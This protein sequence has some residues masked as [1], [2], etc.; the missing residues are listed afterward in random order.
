M[1]TARIAASVALAL[2]A[3][4]VVGTPPAPAQEACVP[5]PFVND[6]CPEWTSVYDGATTG[7]V[8]SIDTA[9]AITTAPG[10][11]PIF[12]AG[13]TRSDETG[14][15]MTTIAYAASGARLWTARYHRP[16]LGVEIAS[17]VAVSPD[18]TTVFTVG[19]EDVMVGGDGVATVVAY[20]AAT[21]QERWVVTH[22]GE[23]PGNDGARAVVVSPD[24][25]TLYVAMSS[26]SA[27]GD[28]DFLTLAL[29]AD[30]G[31]KEWSD[32]YAGPAGWGDGPADIALAPDSSALYVAGT[33]GTGPDSSVYR[34]LAYDLGG[35]EA[36]TEPRWAA[37]YQGPG[38]GRSTAAAMGVAVDGGTV[39][40]AGTSDGGESLLDWATVAFDADTGAQRWAT[41]TGSNGD[42]RA[43]ALAVA[44][45]R[46][47][48]TGRTIGDA[49]NVQDVLVRRP[50]SVTAGYDAG[51]GVEVWRHERALPGHLGEE[52]LAVAASPDGSRVY[53]ADHSGA[54]T[55]GSG[56]GC[57]YGESYEC[58]YIGDPGTV[59]LT[60]IASDDGRQTWTARAAGT[61]N[62]YRPSAVPVVATGS[63]VYLAA[64]YAYPF[65]LSNSGAQPAGNSTDLWTMAFRVPEVA[66][67]NYTCA[68]EPRDPDL[69][70]MGAGSGTPQVRA[71]GSLVEASDQGSFWASCE[72][73]SGDYFE[74]TVRYHFEVETAPGVWD[75][76]GAGFA[77][78]VSSV[79]VLGG[80]TH[81]AEAIV[82]GTPVCPE[83]EIAF[84][85][86]D[87]S[88]GLPHRLCVSLFEIAGCSRPWTHERIG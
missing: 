41:R 51:D 12:V 61:G 36:P 68:I 87:P 21:G 77:C 57:S 7:P 38:P 86:D 10:G 33:E 82:P 84:P 43:V 59:V 35:P 26:R 19:A 66:P 34:T 2:A 52:S 27:E 44:A 54:L 78:T 25:A 13:E 67:I 14:G 37:A 80:G 39:F 31:D 75:R 85:E 50:A 5:V 15:D 49:V 69:S 47:V 23:A 4:A 60:A 70:H 48:V 73:L 16:A 3:A 9:A 20:D 24:G 11:S 1:A 79:K 76:I 22:D 53:V 45:D 40:V 46:V 28:T 65:A 81:I 42:D 72:T 74:V 18:G 83:A 71:G 30:T 17:D 32:R 62:L 29:D 8:L 58:R 56:G 64:T 6:R 63:R 88:L 55:V